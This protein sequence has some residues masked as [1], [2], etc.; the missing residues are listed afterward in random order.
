LTSCSNTHHHCAPP[1]ATCRGLRADP[2]IFRQ[3]YEPFAVRPLSS[4]LLQRLTAVGTARRDH[5]NAVWQL[6]QP[7]DPCHRRDRRSN[8]PAWLRSCS[9][10][11]RCRAQEGSS[12]QATMMLAKSDANLK[13]SLT[14]AVKEV[15]I[16]TLIKSAQGLAACPHADRPPRT[17]TKNSFLRR[18]SL[19]ARCKNPAIRHQDVDVATPS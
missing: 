13:E 9:G 16:A 10:V 8:S 15:Q 19:C 6:P 12:Q 17:V 4:C 5:L 1:A 2:V 11:S 18:E 3:L 7:V 14:I